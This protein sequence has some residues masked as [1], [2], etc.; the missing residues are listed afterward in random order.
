MFVDR[1]SAALSAH[2]QLQD[3]ARR[4]GITTSAFVDLYA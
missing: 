2:P 4:Q 1:K 3:S